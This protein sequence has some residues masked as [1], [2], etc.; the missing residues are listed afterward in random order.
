MMREQLGVE[1]DQIEIKQGSPFIDHPLKD[2]GIRS[3]HNVMVIAIKRAGGEML[4][5]PSGET[6]IEEMDCLIAIG[7]R[8]SLEALEK[9]SNPTTD[10]NRR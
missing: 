7:S 1:L 8:I 10:M 3:D 2:T 4:F 6:I 9:K 5:N